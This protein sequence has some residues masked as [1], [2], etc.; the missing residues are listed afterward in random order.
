M[1]TKLIFSLIL[2][3]TIGRFCSPAVH[4][5]E[6]MWDIITVLGE[7]ENESSLPGSGASAPGLVGA[8]VGDFFHFDDGSVP[9][10]AGGHD[11]QQEKAGV[12][13]IQ[14][15][16]VDIAGWF[17]GGVSGGFGL[18]DAASCDFEFYS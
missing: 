14:Y 1:N 16:S 8:R 3:L 10:G 17:G 2:L 9:H 12:W 7:K 5:A 6:K 15:S 11:D 4:A 13:D 18:A